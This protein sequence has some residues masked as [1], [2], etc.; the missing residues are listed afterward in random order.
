M[1]TTLEQLSAGLDDLLN[2]W[3]DLVN[4]QETFRN[5]VIA[6]LRELCAQVGGAPAAAAAAVSMVDVEQ[7][8]QA[9]LSAALAKFESAASATVAAVAQPAVAETPAAV[10]A[11][12]DP[13]ATPA[14]DSA[15]STPEAAGAAPIQQPQG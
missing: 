5:T 12:V 8:I 6:T 4:P 9:H 11:P 2:R 10:A 7:A 14:S 13:A 3:G 1:S 15:S